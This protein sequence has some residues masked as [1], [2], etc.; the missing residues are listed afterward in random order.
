MF[1]FCDEFAV[2][3][4]GDV[5]VP[6]QIQV[7]PPFVL[8]CHWSDGVGIP[9]AEALKLAVPP[10]QFRAAPAIPNPHAPPN[11]AQ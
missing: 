7:A 11:R 5:P 1:P 8:T 4:S 6:A 10:E 3:V 9:L 2:K